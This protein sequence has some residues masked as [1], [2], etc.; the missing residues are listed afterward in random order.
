MKDSTFVTLLQRVI[1]DV[2]PMDDASLLGKQM[3][4]SCRG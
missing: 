1:G 2:L 3:R 4:S